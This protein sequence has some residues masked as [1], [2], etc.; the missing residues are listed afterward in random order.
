MDMIWDFAPQFWD[1][2]NDTAGV[3]VDESPDVGFQMVA[4]NVRGDRGEKLGL[5]TAAWDD[6]NVVYAMGNALDRDKFIERAFQGRAIPGYGPIPPGEKFY[7]RD[8][9]GVSTR[10]FDPELAQKLIK[11]AGWEDGLEGE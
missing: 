11:E 6:I 9:S 3:I 1:G 7:F 4:F 2:L 5:E 10:A 8:L